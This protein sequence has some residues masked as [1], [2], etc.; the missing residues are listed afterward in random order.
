VYKLEERVQ[1]IN[2]DF[3]NWFKVHDPEMLRDSC[4]FLDPPWF[5]GW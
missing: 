2:D 4:I 5:V 3:V 1:L